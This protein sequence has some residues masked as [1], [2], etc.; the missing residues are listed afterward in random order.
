MPKGTTLFK[1]GDRCRLFVFVVIGKIR[2]DLA[3]ESGSNLLLYRLSA[4]DTCVLTTSCLMSGDQYC[5]EATVEEDASI[6]TMPATEF[7]TSINQ[8]ELFRS[9]VFSSFSQRLTALMTKVDEIAFRSVERR[10]AAALLHHSKGAGIAQVT[11][12]MLATEIGTAREVISRKL[13]RWESDDIIK[14]GRGEI[15]LLS[16]ESLELIA[17]D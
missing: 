15:E 9:F 13:S 12:D 8:S 7:F 6:L 11:H 16:P 3:S 1:A 5:A 10:L 14:R 2:V 17:R 4:N